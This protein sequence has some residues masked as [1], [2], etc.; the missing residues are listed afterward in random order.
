M[1][2]RKGNLMFPSI[3]H[4][5]RFPYTMNACA[6]WV[7]FCLDTAKEIGEPTGPVPCDYAPNIQW[8]RGYYDFLAAALHE[9]RLMSVIVDKYVEARES[10]FAVRILDRVA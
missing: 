3:E 5:A 2:V 1:V 6:D 10:L 7:K 4:L 8:P 9:V